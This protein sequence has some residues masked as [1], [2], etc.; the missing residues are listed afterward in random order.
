VAENQITIFQTPTCQQEI[1]FVD[2]DTIHWKFKVI[3][4]VKCKKTL[5]ISA[6]VVSIITLTDLYALLKMIP[7]YSDTPGQLLTPDGA[8]GFSWVQF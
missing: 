2:S 4:C 5:L 7:G 6:N 3:E 8:G 1:L